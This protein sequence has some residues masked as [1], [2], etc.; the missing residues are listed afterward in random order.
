[1]TNRAI[2]GKAD[3]AHGERTKAGIARARVRGTEWGAHGKVLAARYKARA[4]EFAEALR[5]LI[6]QIA[7]EVGTARIG[8]TAL[9]RE[10]NTRA[11]PTPS[12]GGRWHPTTVRRLFERLGPTFVAEIR[13]AACAKIVRDVSEHVPLDDPIWVRLRP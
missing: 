5:P 6:V 7:S 9:A 10:L 8:A 3:P 2:S 13:K 12:G 11:V 4:E 1:M